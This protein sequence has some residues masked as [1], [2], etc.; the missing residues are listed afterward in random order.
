MPA[1]AKRPAPRSVSTVLARGWALIAGVAIAFGLAALTVSVVQKPMYAA[2]TTLYLTSGGTIVPSAYDSLS[3]SRERVG[4]YAQLLYS[5]AVLMPAVQ[6]VGLNLTLEQARQRVTVDVNPQVVLITL[7][8]SDRD[9][10]VAQKFADALAKSMEATVSALEVPGASTEPLVKVRQVTT[11]TLN[12]GPAEPR[13][14]VNVSVAVAAGLIAGCLLALSREFLNNK[15]RDENDAEAAFGAPAL[16]VVARKD[17]A[18]DAFRTLRTRL[19]VLDPP[20]RKLLITSA[21]PY[22]GT[23]AVAIGAGKSLAQAANSVVIVDANFDNPEVTKWVGSGGLGLA[24]VLRGAPLGDVIQRGVGGVKTLAV[25]GAGTKVSGHPADFFSS[26]AFRKVL[27]DLSEQFDYV[28]IDSAA[29]LENSGTEAIA[30]SV[31]GVLLV[32]RQS[33]SKMTDLVESRTRLTN[34]EAR[35]VGV[36][37]FSSR[38]E[39]A[40]ERPKEPAKER[41][42]VAV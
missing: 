5:Q 36:V 6:A 38:P 25:L 26:A 31:D 12:S 17:Q 29:M 35:V 27:D 22:E 30:L 4:S 20:V 37:F 21:R 19:A 14:L 10:A 41:I 1:K 33:G 39:R 13:I 8:A 3:A 7:S 40:K 9:P 28:I 16:A 11:A 23:T 15:V 42:D 18:Q 24:D 34:V 2:S 32:S